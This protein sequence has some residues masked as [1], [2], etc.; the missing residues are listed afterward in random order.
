MESR[1]MYFKDD[2]RNF[3]QQNDLRMLPLCL[4]RLAESGKARKRNVTKPSRFERTDAGIRD[5]YEKY[6]RYFPKQK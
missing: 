5:A 2:S 1:I 3:N 6:L 4:C